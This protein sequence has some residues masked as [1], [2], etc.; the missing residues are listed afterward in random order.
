MAKKSQSNDPFK[1]I[2]LRYPEAAPDHP[3]YK[4]GGFVSFP[5]SRMIAQRAWKAK[6]KRSAK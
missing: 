6:G 4:L 1:K 3:I 5:S 2:R